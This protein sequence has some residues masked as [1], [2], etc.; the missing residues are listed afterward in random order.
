MTVSFPAEINDN[1]PNMLF[2]FFF[3]SVNQA[4]AVSKT[5]T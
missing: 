3:V 5:T 1:V 2:F 4:I